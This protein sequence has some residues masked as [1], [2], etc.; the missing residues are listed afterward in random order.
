MRRRTNRYE[1]D[2][3]VEML[4]VIRR[5]VIPSPVCSKECIKPGFE[6]R[7]FSTVQCLDPIRVKIHK[8]YL[9]AQCRKT[10]AGD[11]IDVA[12]ADNA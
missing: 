4:L 7:R 3:T 12:T 5:G 8:D 11:R 9:V 10:R 6:E 1:R 2:I